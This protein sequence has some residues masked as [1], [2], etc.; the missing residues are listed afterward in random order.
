ML[1]VLS[2]AACS[3]GY[4]TDDVAHIDPAHMTQ[5]QLLLALNALGKDAQQGKRG[6]YSLHADCDPPVPAT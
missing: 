2:L 6:R 4:P 3:D 1:C 5:A